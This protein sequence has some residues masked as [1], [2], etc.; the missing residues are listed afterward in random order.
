[1]K[2]LYYMLAAI[3]I[4]APFNLNAETNCVEID[5]QD[6]YEL[7]FAKTTECSVVPTCCK[8]AEN[9]YYGCKIG[10]IVSTSTPEVDCKNKEDRRYAPQYNRCKMMLLTNQKPIYAEGI[11]LGDC[12]TLCTNKEIK[13][14]V[15]N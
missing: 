12:R 15:R 9:T 4:L 6:E 14:K 13:I 3:T 2:N 1:M 5:C 10:T 11:S 8:D 7:D